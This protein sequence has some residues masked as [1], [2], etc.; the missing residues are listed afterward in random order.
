MALR[1][2]ETLQTAIQASLVAKYGL[3]LFAAR[4]FQDVCARLCSVGDSDNK[5]YISNDLCHR[6]TAAVHIHNAAAHL[7]AE[8]LH[9]FAW[10][11]A[12]FLF[13]PL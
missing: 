10:L 13:C 11:L 8:K 5:V 7:L 9:R 2:L 3:Y 1:A 6:Y 12:R 4:P